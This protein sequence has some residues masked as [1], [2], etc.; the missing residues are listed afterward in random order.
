MK[1]LPLNFIFVFQR[2]TYFTLENAIKTLN[3]NLLHINEDKTQITGGHTIKTTLIDAIFYMYTHMTSRVIWGDMIFTSE[4]IKGHWR[5]TFSKWGHAFTTRPRDA[6]CLHVYS[7]GPCKYNKLDRSHLRH[8][9]FLMCALLNVVHHNWSYLHFLDSFPLVF[10]S[11]L[12]F[13]HKKH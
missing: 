3:I 11:I 10:F 2:L 9:L 1:I 8:N 6:I 5:S 4:V 13:L 12:V 7:C